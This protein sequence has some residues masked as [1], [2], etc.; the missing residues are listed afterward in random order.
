M[1]LSLTHDLTYP[2]TPFYNEETMAWPLSTPQPKCRLCVGHR[3]E[4]LG[5]QRNTI[6]S[7]PLHG[8]QGLVEEAI[9]IITKV[10]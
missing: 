10:K 4:V 9:K 2:M 7:L 1:C 8:W 5:L 3:A 6:R